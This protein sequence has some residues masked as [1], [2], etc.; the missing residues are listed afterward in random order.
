MEGVNLGVLGPAVAPFRPRVI[1]GCNGQ[2]DQ[3]AGSH[4]SIRRVDDDPKPVRAHPSAEQLLA[5]NGATID[6]HG[7]Q[8]RVE[9]YSGVHGRCASS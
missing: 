5:R 3:E 2:L 1:E 6:L 8:I 9:L 7:E 4:S